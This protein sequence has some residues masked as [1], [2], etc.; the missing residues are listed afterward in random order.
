MKFKNLPN[1]VLDIDEYDVT[2]VISHNYYKLLLDKTNNNNSEY[3]WV[4]WVKEYLCLPRRKLSTT[5]SQE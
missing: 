4:G 5:G 2:E 3:L 1:K